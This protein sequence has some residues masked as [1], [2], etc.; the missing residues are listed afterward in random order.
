V[1]RDGLVAPHPQDF[2]EAV[3][4]TPVGVEVDVAQAGTC[5]LRGRERARGRDSLRAQ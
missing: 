3:E 1:G 5:L 2:T 4:L